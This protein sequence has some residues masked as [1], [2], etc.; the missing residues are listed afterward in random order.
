MTSILVLSVIWSLALYIA[1]VL[2]YRLYFHPLAKFPGTKLAAATGLYEAYHDILVAP[3]GQFMYEIQRMHKKYGPVVRISPDEIHINDPA[4]LK[5]LY[6]FT[7]VRHKLY[8]AAR[9]LGNEDALFATTDHHTHQMRRSAIGNIF[10]KSAVRDAEQ[11]IHDN[12]KKLELRI[13]KQIRRDG[14]T[15]MRTNFLAFA[16]TVVNDYCLGAVPSLQLLEADDTNEGEA[17]RWFETIS[18]LTSMTSIA[19][20][21]S[22]LSSFSMKLPSFL[23][24]LNPHIERIVNMRR[25]LETQAISE[26][27]AHSSPDAKEQA[28]PATGRRHLFGAILNNP[29]MPP[30]EQHFTRIAQEGAL[31]VGAGGETSARIL[32]TASFFLAADKQIMSKL[33]AELQSA[34][35][36]QN[37]T[38]S[39]KELESL[40]YLTAVI[41]ESLRF[42]GILTSRSPL[43]SDKPLHHGKWLI[44]AGTPVSMTFRHLLRDPTVFPNP[45]S[46]QPDRWLTKDEGMMERMNEYF[47]PFGRGSRMCVGLHLA[48]A[49][50]YIAIAELFRNSV[51]ELH[52]GTS[53]RD[54]EIVRD[55]GVGEV[56][57]DS[58]GVK[59]TFAKVI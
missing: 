53:L 15:E 54:V 33:Q 51:F 57:P 52:G 26:I 35:P 19:R 48:W 16:I 2:I 38:P 40:P 28:S 14:F 46:F 56:S 44:P 31:V 8:S 20:Q 3:G 32:T 10:S 6:T 43:I 50:I 39:L 25:A 17:V 55:C 41:K 7:E 9:F 36:D 29:N 12:V 13:A 4:W 18:S 45:E 47:L 11:L 5:E 34:I 24:S 23:L 22:W 21:C 1:T 42:Q 59:L 58:Q 49:E 27:K 30:E 37:S